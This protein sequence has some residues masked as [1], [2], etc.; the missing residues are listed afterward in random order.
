MLSPLEQLEALER[1]LERARL[2]VKMGG[3]ED[4]PN[5]KGLPIKP[6]VSPDDEDLLVFPWRSYQS[7][8][9][10]PATWVHG[11]A[12]YIHQLISLRIFGIIPQRSDWM[13][14]DHINGDRLDNRRENLRLVKTNGGNSLNISSTKFITGVRFNKYKGKYESWASIYRNHPGETKNKK[15]AYLGAW[16]TL[17]EAIASRKTW[18]RLFPLLDP[19]SRIIKT[20]EPRPNTA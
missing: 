7:S 15:G 13:C 17:S 14:I 8:T 3:G 6:K 20:Y 4:D 11:Q 12:I 2:T 1:A 19:S 10:Y 5:R 18:E 9:C 16:D